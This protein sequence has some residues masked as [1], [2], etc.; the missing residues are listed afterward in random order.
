MDRLSVWL[1][2]LR[3]LL[4]QLKELS[5]QR[6]LLAQQSTLAL[7]LLQLVLQ[8]LEPEPGPEQVQFI[9]D[10]VEFKATLFIFFL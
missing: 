5:V 4:L 2:L 8:L 6:H 10:F 9:A 1:S 3:L 7:G